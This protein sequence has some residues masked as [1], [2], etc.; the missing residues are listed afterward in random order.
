MLK[1]CPAFGARGELTAGAAVLRSPK[2]RSDCARDGGWVGATVEAVT[3]S[4]V[5][6]DGM[7][8]GGTT[9]RSRRGTGSRVRDSARLSATERRA[10]GERGE[11]LDPGAR[12]NCWAG[13]GWVEASARWGGAGRGKRVRGHGVT[14]Q[15]TSRYCQAYHQPFR[16]LASRVVDRLGYGP[17]QPRHLGAAQVLAH[18]R[19]RR[20]QAAG[21]GSDAQ[22]GG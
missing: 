10:W 11:R 15:Q 8:D 7:S 12:L 6:Q 16:V 22:C 1:W 2:A 20:P 14:G 21:D 4:V 3:D 5:G 17:T 18:R 9:A 19:R 13:D